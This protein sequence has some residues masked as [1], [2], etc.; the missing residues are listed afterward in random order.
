MYLKY[1]FIDKIN[2]LPTMFGMICA[3]ILSVTINGD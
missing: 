3:F 2:N 1:N